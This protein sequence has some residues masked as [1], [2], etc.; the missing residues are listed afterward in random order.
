MSGAAVGAAEAVAGPPVDDA[1]PSN[2][3]MITLVVML[4]MMMSIIDAS[5]VNVSVPHMMGTFGASVTEIAWVVT[6]YSLANVIFIPLTAWIGSV[7]GRSRMYGAAIAVFTVASVLCGIAPTL[8]TLIAARVLQGAAAGLL[9]PAGQAILYESFPPE[10]RGSSMAVFGLGVMVGPAVGPTL[11]GYITDNYG[12]PWIF[13]I[14]LPIGIV[15]TVLVPLVLRDPPYLKRR[16]SAGGDIVGIVLLASGIATMQYV[17]EYGADASWFQTDWVV[18]ATTATLLLLGGFVV[19][20][21]DHPDPAVDLRVF[22]DASF[23]TAS[24]V[25]VAIGVGLMGGMFMLPLFLQQLVGF[26]ATQTG[27]VLVPGALA[28]AVAMPICGR[29]SDRYD[30]RVLSGFG[31]AVFALSMW[32]MSRL[33]GRAGASDLLLPQVL[34]GVGMGFCFVPLSVAALAQI[35]KERMGQATG[36]F[37]LTRSIGG[38]LGV[39]WLASLLSSYRSGHMAHLVGNVT[40][41]SDVARGQLGMLTAGLAARGMPAS[42]GLGLQMLYGRVARASAELAFRDMFVTIVALFLAS[43]PLLMLVRR[44]IAKPAEPG[45]APAPMAHAE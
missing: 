39:A 43:L 37:T 14:N 34:R 24:T 22:A 15:A 42:S 17:L 45:A 30:P 5:I 21:L 29:L 20:E 27:I 33:D 41:Y 25:N 40:P 12:W 18:I 32:M 19:W 2:P 1:P 3:W 26:T 28:T 4:G 10:R 11:G 13:L 23:R 8:A 16:A 38:S 31:L 7:V 35:P 9:M 6:A 44:R 36:L